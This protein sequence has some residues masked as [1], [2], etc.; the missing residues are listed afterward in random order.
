MGLIIAPNLNNTYT[1]NSKSCNCQIDLRGKEFSKFE[2][3]SPFFAPLRDPSG[4]TCTP[5]LVGP[6]GGPDPQVL[7]L[8]MPLS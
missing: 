5:P 6:L 3:I 4:V 1:E 8:A 2:T 7:Q